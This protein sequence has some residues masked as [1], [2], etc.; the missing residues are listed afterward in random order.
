[1]GSLIEYVFMAGPKLSTRA[2]QN[3]GAHNKFFILILDQITCF[4]NLVTSHLFI[5]SI[6]NINWKLNL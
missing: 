6:V 4:S 1:M 2:S 3:K 5:V